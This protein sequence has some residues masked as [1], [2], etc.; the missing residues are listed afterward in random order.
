MN[1]VMDRYMIFF[2]N[3]CTF[4]AKEIYANMYLE[5]FLLIQVNVTLHAVV[6]IIGFKLF[7]CDKEDNYGIH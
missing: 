7:I 4:L 2:Y 5:D 6:I 3:K 1:G